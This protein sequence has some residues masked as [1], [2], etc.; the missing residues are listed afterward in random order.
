MKG[1][2]AQEENTTNRNSDSLALRDNRLHLPLLLALLAYS[3]YTNK[4]HPF[5]QP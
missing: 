4:L 2:L 5:Q 3:F 1:T